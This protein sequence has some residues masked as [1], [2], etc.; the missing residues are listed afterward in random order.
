M[1][2]QPWRTRARETAKLAVRHGLTRLDLDIAR[3][4][5]VR[6]LQRTL[7]TRGID[8]VMDIGANVGQFGRQLRHAGFSGRIVSVEPLSSAYAQLARRAARDPRWECLRSAV[9][10]DGEA[11]MNVA[12]NSYSSSILAVTAS[13]VDAAP[14]SET[15]A[16]EAVPMV[17]LAALVRDRQLDPAA[18]LLKVDTQ[19]YESQVLDSAEDMLGEFGAVQ[20]E[21][22]VIELYAG[23]VLHEELVDR[24][25]ALGFIL[26][27]MDTGISGPDGR[28]LQ[29]DGLFVP[30]GA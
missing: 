4:P 8:T 20:L 22:S 19:G 5:Y 10:T 16:T 23:Q 26:W 13:H 25:H 27:S 1:R 30:G 28:L 14:D 12:S 15:V 2:E 18:T 21:L 7:E 17:S 9:G 29:Y 6:R 11:T 3:D 24:L